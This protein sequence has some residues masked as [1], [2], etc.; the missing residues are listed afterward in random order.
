[1]MREKIKDI[2]KGLDSV[3]SNNERERCV[4]EKCEESEKMRS[5]VVEK[6][7]I[8]CKEVEEELGYK[9]KELMKLSKMMNNLNMCIR[10]KV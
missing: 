3:K 8:K 5:D 7:V 1:M 9:W 2:K 6:D 10:V 4:I